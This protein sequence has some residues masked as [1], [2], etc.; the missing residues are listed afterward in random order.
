[1]FQW[2]REEVFLS[3]GLNV[4]VKI[5]CKLEEVV[6]HYSRPIVLRTFCVRI[7]Q[8]SL[9]RGVLPRSAAVVE[10]LVVRWVAE[11]GVPS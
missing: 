5:K 8:Y 1:M 6:L 3:A 2:S 7:F 4:E 9:K 10:T 11:L